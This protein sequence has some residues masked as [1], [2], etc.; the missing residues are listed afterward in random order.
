MNEVQHVTDVARGI[1]DFGMT[2]MIGAFYLILSA[3]MMITI[4]K[5]FKSIINKILED[6]KQGMQDL[7]KETRQQNEMLYDLSDGL[8]TET[9]LRLRNISGFAFDLAVEQV[10][11]IIK[12]V[13]TENHIADREATAKKIRTLL[14]NIY[15]DR[16]SRFDPFFYHGKSISSFCNPEWIE[17]VAQV[18]EGEIY[19]ELGADNGRAYTNVK[20]IY[21][22]IKI[23]FYRRLNN[24]DL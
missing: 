11:R 2:A 20:M 16:K 1:T 8:R 14:N 9:Q 7:L 21:D 3:L 6:N 24:S 10:C 18:V 23:D 12:K 13:R 17:K 19:N 22:N 15:E 5:W 4:F